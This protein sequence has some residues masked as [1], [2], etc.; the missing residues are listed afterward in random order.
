MF[1][2]LVCAQEIL[3]ADFLVT[4]ITADS[5]RV[6]RLLPSPGVFFKSI[7]LFATVHAQ[8]QGHVAELLE[9][10]WTDFTRGDLGFWS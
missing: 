2:Q 3:V 7:L 6:H 5:V 10:H 1:I 9:E 4:N 8:I